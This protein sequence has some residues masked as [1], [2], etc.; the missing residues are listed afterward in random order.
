MKVVNPLEYPGWDDLLATNPASSF[1]HTTAWARVLSEAY[2]FTPHYFVAENG[3]L[4]A[5]L[6]VMEVS[7]RLTGR[8]GVSLPFTDYSAPIF[9]ETS[10]PSE[11]FDSIL[12][13]GKTAGWAYLEIRDSAPFLI[14]VPA[15]STYF[16][17]VL[18]LSS[19]DE[20]RVHSAFHDSTK[21]NIRKAVKE[22]VT[23]Q[24]LETEA[25]VREFYRLNCLT[26]KAHGLP[27]QP[28]RFFLKV[29]EHVISKGLGFVVLAFHNDV[30]IAGNVYFHHGQN[31]IYKY[32]ASD[33]AF[34][35][36]RASNV[37]M[38]EAIR[39]YCRSGFRK[40]CLGRTE[41]ENHGL[42]RYKLGWGT[43]GRTFTYHRYDLRTGGFVEG[44]QFPQE[45]FKKIFRLLPIGVSKVIGE[46]LYRHVG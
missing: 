12:D 28:Y 9:G 3:K 21:R 20:T 33:M 24:R 18:D 35:H 26:R 23:V 31:A 14:G 27:P 11:A 15:L 30:T 29:F 44:K 40:L 19:G 6:P 36:L 39:W 5:L 10:D 8:R 38:W 25:S 4:V 45:I 42:M 46:K 22:G 43:E 13:H 2:Q 34:Q 37:V 7:S 1:F 16:G 32:G 17:H 41:P